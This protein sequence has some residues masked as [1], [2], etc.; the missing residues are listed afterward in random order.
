[1]NVPSTDEAR[2]GSYLDRP[3][4]PA[5]GLTLGEARGF[6]FAVAC[7]P[8]LVP[9]S[10]WISV[11]FGGDGP[12]FETAAEAQQVLGAL[13]AL[14]NEVTTLARGNEPR[15]PAAC[16]LLPDPAANM[17]PEAPIAAWSRGFRQGHAWLEELWDVPLPDEMEVELGSV[18]MALIFFG[19]GDGVESLLAELNPQ[20][21]A[22]EAAA[23]I[24]GIFPSAVASYAELGH[25][26]QEAHRPAPPTARRK[27]GKTRGRRPKG[28]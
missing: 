20:R 1:M 16:A 18:L 5:D 6:L 24:Q 3:E 28:R 27:P 22:L 21:P 23:T 14:Y 12:T 7:A 11:V 17:A 8:E 13:M 4:R 2:L 19:F 10:E 26:I 15:L 9:P 25:I